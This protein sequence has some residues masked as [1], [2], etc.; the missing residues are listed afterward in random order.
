[1]AEIQASDEQIIL[2]TRIGGI[3]EREPPV[4]GAKAVAKQI[5]IVVAVLAMPTDE[6]HVACIHR[7]TLEHCAVHCT[8]AEV[9]AIEVP[10]ARLKIFHQAALNTVECEAVRATTGLRV[11][12]R[13]V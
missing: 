11:E 4:P 1:G 10:I 2:V 12:G 8:T 13:T 9:E 5:G 3:A 7:A 6:G